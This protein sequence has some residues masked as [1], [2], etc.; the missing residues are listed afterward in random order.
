MLLA[1]SDGVKEFLGKGFSVDKLPNPVMSGTKAT[2]AEME[3]ILMMVKAGYPNREI[4][5]RFELGPTTMWKRLRAIQKFG[6]I[7]PITCRYCGK[8]RTHRGL[9][10]K[11]I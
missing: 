11:H 4:A 5:A 9:C 10:G 3:A 7:P 6:I 2:C 1:R 8:D